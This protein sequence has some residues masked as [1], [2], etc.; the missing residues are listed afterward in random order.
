MEEVEEEYL[1]F[2]CL[3]TILFMHE[4]KRSRRMASEEK[5]RPD[6]IV[7]GFRLS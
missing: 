4:V 1:V 3:M 5:Y 6:L 2:P 7:I